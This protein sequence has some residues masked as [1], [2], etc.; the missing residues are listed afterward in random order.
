MTKNP[1]DEKS[2]LMWSEPRTAEYV[3]GRRKAVAAQQ[4]VCC[5]HTP[6]HLIGHPCCFNSDRP[7]CRC[8]RRALGLSPGWYDVEDAVRDAI[9]RWDA[10]NLPAR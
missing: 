4:A 10:E 9:A 2:L 5:P 1:V 6:P 7:A 8:E 3:A